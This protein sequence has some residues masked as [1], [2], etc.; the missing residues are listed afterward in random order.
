M[1]WGIEKTLL[2]RSMERGERAI[3]HTCFY[4]EPPSSEV[5]LIANALDL[6]PEKF[7]EEFGMGEFLKK[8]KPLKPK[9]PFLEIKFS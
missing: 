9:L 8:Q 1:K 3:F 5:L 6:T 4:T 2:R 7:A